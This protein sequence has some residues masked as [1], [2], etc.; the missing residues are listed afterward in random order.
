MSKA[1]VEAMAKYLYPYILPY[2]TR[3]AEGTIPWDKLED[4]DRESARRVVRNALKEADT[5]TCT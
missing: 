5:T 2:T 1:Q 3:G 4:K